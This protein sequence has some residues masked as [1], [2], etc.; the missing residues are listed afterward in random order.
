[1]DSMVVMEKMIAI[2]IVMFSRGALVGAILKIEECHPSD[3]CPLQMHQFK[4][5]GQ[6]V[7]LVAGKKILTSQD[8]I[9]LALKSISIVQ[10][11]SLISQ[12]LPGVQNLCNK[13]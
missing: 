12:L 3:S 8:R 10:T 4:F 2:K 9:F 6:V 13:L 1:M 7:V 5:M 11:H